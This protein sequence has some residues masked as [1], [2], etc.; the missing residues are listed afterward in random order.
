MTNTANTTE[1][2]MATLLASNDITQAMPR[3]GETVTGTVLSVS[4]NEAYLDLEGYGVGVIRGREIEDE[5][6]E[7]SHL[8]VGETATATVLEM[9]NE[10]G[11]VE[12]SFR[13]AGHRKAWDALLLMKRSQDVVDAEVLDANRGGLMMKVG[14]V[15]GFLPVSQLS[16]EHYPRVEG[17]DKNKILEV[18]SDFVHQTFRVKVIDV[19]EQDEKLIVSEKAALEEAQMERLSK[20]AVGNVVQGDITGVV[21]FGAFVEFED[22]LEGL[23]HISEL[24]WQR[25]DDPRSVVKVGD[26]VRAKIIAIDGMKISL[27]MKQLTDDPWQKAAERFTLGQVVTGKVLKMNPF[28]AF[29]ELDADIHGLAHISE[30]EGPLTIGETYEFK[31]ISLE[32]ATHRLG[33]SRKALQT[34]LTQGTVSA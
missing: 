10:N 29:V 5:S 18:L 25:V 34:P 8:R 24:A 27:S 11:N 2:P 3:V 22:G 17:G 28:G 16:T 1:R 7:S 4:K 32:P 9:E 6:G 15:I 30:L 20:Y 12:L 23:V 13:H 26:R 21:D 31:V 14:N 33:L 19:N